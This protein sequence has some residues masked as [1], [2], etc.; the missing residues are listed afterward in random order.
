[1]PANSQQLTPLSSRRPWTSGQLQKQPGRAAVGG[2]TG[3]QNETH[4]EMARHGGG[5]PQDQGMKKEATIKKATAALSAGRQGARSARAG[6]RAEARQ[7]TPEVKVEGQRGRARPVGSADL[8]SGR[9]SSAT[10][11][12]ASWQPDGGLRLFEDQEGISE[13]EGAKHGPSNIAGIQ[14]AA[15]KSM[16]A[17]GEDQCIWWH[18]RIPVTEKTCV[19]AISIPPPSCCPGCCTTIVVL[20]SIR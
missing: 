4:V 11:D 16:Y 8:L 10:S 15:S 2:R 13:D 12:A 14:Q 9:W 3:T 18:C 1:M 20:H 5:T 17:R 7:Q 19:P 6:Q